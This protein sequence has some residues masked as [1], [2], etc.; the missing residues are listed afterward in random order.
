MAVEPTTHPDVYEPPR[1]IEPAVAWIVEGTRVTRDI[2]AAIPLVFEAYA[3]LVNDDDPLAGPHQERQLV[4][5]LRRHTPDQPW[6]LGYL[7]TGAH[8]IVRPDEPRVLLYARWGYVIGQGT[9]DQALTARAFD[10]WRGA[11]PDVIFPVDRSFLVSMLWDDD[12]RCVGGSRA[13]IDDV[14]AAPGWTARR[15]EPGQDATP[16]GHVSF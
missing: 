15:V 2:D 12:W 16:P 8:D 3:T 14:V 10:P 7:D 5:I 13:L 4:E 1:R 11:L 9:P 6:W